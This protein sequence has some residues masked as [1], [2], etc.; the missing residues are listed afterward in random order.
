MIY[1]TASTTATFLTTQDIV[2]DE[3]TKAAAKTSMYAPISPLKEV[4]EPGK[5]K[6]RLSVS[7]TVTEVNHL[8]LFQIFMNTPT[9]SIVYLTGHSL[10]TPLS[11]D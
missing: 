3:P 5:G 11:A 1:F 2:L 6:R 9:C 10:N 7:G 8:I 4:K